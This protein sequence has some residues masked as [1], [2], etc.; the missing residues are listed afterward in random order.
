MVV[1][2]GPAVDRQR[3]GQ[4]EEEERGDPERLLGGVIFQQFQSLPKQYQQPEDRAGV[5]NRLS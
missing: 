5:G 1:L 2:A 4:Q 3:D